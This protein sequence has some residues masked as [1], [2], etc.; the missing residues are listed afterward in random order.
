MVCCLELDAEHVTPLTNRLSAAVRIT[1][2]VENPGL[3]LQGV[4]YFLSQEGAPTSWKY[5]T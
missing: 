3:M 1:R 5:P 4:A 2:L